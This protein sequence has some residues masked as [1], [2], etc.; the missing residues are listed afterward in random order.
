MKNPWL[1]KR[2]VKELTSQPITISVEWGSVQ[3]IDIHFVVQ[4]TPMT[5]YIQYTAM[6]QI[7]NEEDARF[8]QVIETTIQ[9]SPI[10]SEVIVVG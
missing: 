8:F 9:S 2:Q 10:Q 7:Q 3:M 6:Q 5:D 4:Y 1:A